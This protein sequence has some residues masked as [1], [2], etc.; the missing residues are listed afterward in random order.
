MKNHSPKYSLRASVAGGMSSLLVS[1]ALLLGSAWAPAWAG[2]S[3]TWS[4]IAGGGGTSRSAQY[5]LTGTLGEPD[6]GAPMSGGSFSLTGGFLAGFAVAQ[7]PGSQTITITYSG[8]NIVLSW[9]ASATGYV[10]QESPAL[11]NGNWTDVPQSPVDNGGI[12]SVTIPLAPG[13][14]FF[15]LKK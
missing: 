4:K 14:H 1:A 6:A 10:L 5:S 13:N 11:V 7:Q 12:R 15:R 8:G 9:A 2:Y 3:I